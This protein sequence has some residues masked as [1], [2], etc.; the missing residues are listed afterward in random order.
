MMKC[1]SCSDTIENNEQRELNTRILCEDCYMDALSPPKGCDPWAVY[2]GTRTSSLSE[3]Q[4]ITAIQAQILE[5]IKNNGEI[6]P[7]MLHA[8]LDDQIS[9]PDLKRELATLRHM[10]KV[11]GKPKDG[12]VVIRLW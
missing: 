12:K 2:L 10:E 7:E 9:Q 5:I 11:R 8:K 6:E 3:D 4:G 1:D